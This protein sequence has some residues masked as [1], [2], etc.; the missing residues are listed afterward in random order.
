MKK[1][2]II[3]VET[4]EYLGTVTTK[5]NN[6]EALFENVSRWLRRHRNYKYVTSEELEKKGFNWEP[7][8]YYVREF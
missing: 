4:G 5:Y 3:N 7:T 2:D 1:I 8:I 6:V